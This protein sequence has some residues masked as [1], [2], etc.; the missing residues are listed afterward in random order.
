MHINIDMCL[1]PPLYIIC[2]SRKRIK[3]EKW[4]EY[5]YNAGTSSRLW[6]DPLDFQ[7]LQ[8]NTLRAIWAVY[9][10]ILFKK[11]KTCYYDESSCNLNVYDK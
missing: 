10:R 1:I 11:N 4:T 3:A 5:M 2:F 9:F 6:T 8:E 7:S